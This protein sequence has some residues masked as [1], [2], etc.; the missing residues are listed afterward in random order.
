MNE[1]DSLY[2][3]S[4]TGV[5][6]TNGQAALMLADPESAKKQLELTVSFAHLGSASIKAACRMLMK[7]TPAVPKLTIYK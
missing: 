7:L 5:N 4:I 3:T 2:G 6:F 1:L